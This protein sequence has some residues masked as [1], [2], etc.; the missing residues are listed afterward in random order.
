MQP[1][2]ELA[3]LIALGD[4]VGMMDAALISLADTFCATP[5]LRGSRNFVRQGTELRHRGSEGG[6]GISMVQRT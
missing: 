1:S 4:G 5:T 3:I 6:L 2:G